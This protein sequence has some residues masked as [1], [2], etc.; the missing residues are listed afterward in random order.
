MVAKPL[1]GRLY[2]ANEIAAFVL[3]L[4][5]I[6]TLSVWG[7][8]TGPGVAGS[9]LL[10]VGAPAAAVV[11]WGMFAAPRARFPLSLPGTLGVKAVVFAAA[12]AALARL[13][14]PALAVALAIV[15]LV[16]T[17]IAVRFRPRP[18]PAPRE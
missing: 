6:A 1:V 8:M 7:F 11:V 10:G 3:E 2:M 12:V 14:R 4:V 9:V 15:L 5:V 16:N 18:W 17:A 13:D